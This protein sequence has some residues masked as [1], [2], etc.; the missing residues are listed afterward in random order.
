MAD[1]VRG[2]L[3][4]LDAL[5][6]AQ[7]QHLGEVPG[8]RLALAVRVGGKDDLAA[9]ALDRRAELVD[10]LAAAL[11]HLV[12]RL[13]AVVDLHAHLLSRQVA[14]VPHGGAHVETVTQKPLQRSGLGGRLDDDQSFCHSP[15]FIPKPGKLFPRPGLRRASYARSLPRR[16]ALT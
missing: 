12:V 15:L 13:E 8:D 6:V 10:G 5:G 9:V 4:E 2:D 3:V 7:L 1:G 16:N 11:H 14:N